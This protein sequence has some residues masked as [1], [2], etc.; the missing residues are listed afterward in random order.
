MKT[1]PV[2]HALC[3][4]YALR[5]AYPKRSLGLKE[6]DPTSDILNPSDPPPTATAVGGSSTGDDVSAVGGS[7]TGGDVGL[8]IS[9][10]DVG[11]TVGRRVGFVGG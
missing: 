1:S 10:V 2:D 8:L 3:R 6:S 11:G 5:N 9:G 7:S 4:P